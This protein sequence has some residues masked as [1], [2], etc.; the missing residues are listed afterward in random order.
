[1]FGFKDRKRSVCFLFNL[2]FFLE[3]ENTDIFIPLRYTGFCQFFFV[4]AEQTASSPALQRQ[5]MFCKNTK[6]P[7]ASG[8]LHRAGSQHVTPNSAKSCLCF[9]VVP[10][11]CFRPTATIQGSCQVL[12]PGFTNNLREKL[13]RCTSH[14]D[15][16]R[17]PYSNCWKP[18]CDQK[19]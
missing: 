6:C 15:G 19:A 2:K 5:T 12:V 1:M 8:N 11:L 9:L 7:T 3:A 18:W 14:R 16:A 4:L 17:N 10:S 13:H